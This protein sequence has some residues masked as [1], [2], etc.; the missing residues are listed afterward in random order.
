MN[1]TN[2]AHTLT[3]WNPSLRHALCF[4]FPR[5]TGGNPHRLLHSL[6]R[7]LAGHVLTTDGEITGG[8]KGKR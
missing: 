2:D 1:T 8:Y 5:L 6:E 4:F 7:S 3:R